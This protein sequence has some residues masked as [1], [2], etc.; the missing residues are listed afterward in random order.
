MSGDDTARAFVLG[1][2]GVPWDRIER[3]T[4]AGHLPNFARMREEGASGPLESTVPATTAVAWP[5][6]TTG[7]NADKH[8]VY[9]F[10]NLAANYTHRMHTSTD[11]RAPALWH[12]LSPAVTGNVPLTYPAED[13][14]GAVVTGMMT[15]RIDAGFTHPPE[16]AEAVRTRIPD[17]QIGLDWSQYGDRPG[18]FVAELRSLVE[19]R[20]ALMELLMERADWRLFFFVYTAP[21]RLQHLVWD[22]DVL[23]QH[24]RQLDDI[25][26]DAMAYA[27]ERGADLYVVSDHGFGPI[28][29]F[30]SANRVLE[31]EGYLTRR[32]QSGT[33]GA[34]AGLGITKESVLSALGRVG[35]T[36][37]AILE[38][39]PHSLADRIASQI[40]GE[41]VLYDVSYA[42]TKAFIHGPGN[43]YVNDADRFDEGVVE[44]GAVPAVK[45][46]LRTVLEQ[47]TDPETG[48]PALDVYDGDD[49]FDDDQSPDLVVR[50]KAGYEVGTSLTEDV[51]VET[52]AKAASHRPTGIFLAR[53]P[54][55]EHGVEI[56]GAT[57]VD[58][59]PTVLHG[60]S[61]AVPRNA[62]GSVLHDVFAAR[63]APG[64]GA[65]SRRDYASRA[66]RTAVDED[67]SDVE[68]RLRG[69]G[70]ME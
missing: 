8:G 44:S 6:I 3:W 28:E 19:S 30:V 63:T 42:E 54:N 49:L 52:G 31:A 67:F 2:D 40:P 69:L 37:Q 55:V 11:L 16:L 64:R 35:I 33:R 38:Y 41:H 27:D 48:R 32:Q 68:D 51:F 57:A 5:A 43:L 70:Y 26:G 47:V 10:Q 14:D 24:Y 7:V 15:P 23:L 46:E 17:Y 62:D 29:K 56:E 21:D 65:V 4:D 61:A 39:V 20:R 12:L 58:V 53:G 1:F 25:L 45:R 50:G 18:E 13:I 66:P 9:A 36:D 22:D 60:A 34:L 59:A